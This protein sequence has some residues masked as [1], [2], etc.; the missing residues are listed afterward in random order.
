MDKDTRNAI[1]RAT[2]KIRRIL[3]EDFA[4]QLDGVFDVRSDGR[5][6]EE[7]GRH[8]SGRQLLLRD[9]I[10]AAVEHK[11]RAGMQPTD[12]VRDY[13]RDAA[14]TTLNRFA[15]LKM[16]EPRGLVQECISRGENSIGFTEFCGLA[17][18]LKTVD[19]AGYRL[20]IE[21]I[22]DELST[23]VKV[24]FDRRDPASALWPRKAAFDEILEI[25]NGSG[26]VGVWN[27]DETIGWIYQFFNSGEERRQ[28]REESQTPR[29]GR[30]LAIR[31]QFF[32]P[33]YVVRF[34]AENSLA[35]IW[36]EMRR[37]DTRI[38]LESEYLVCESFDL[39]Q[40]AGM[41][42][43]Q[44]RTKKDPRSLGAI[45]PACGSGHF[46]LYLF[47][48]F[49][50]IYEEAWHDLDAPTF[51][52]S[53]RTLREDFPELEEF[54]K[55]MPGLILRYNLFGIDIDF[56]CAQIA[57]LALWMRAQRAFKEMNVSRAARPRI[58]RANIVIAEPIPG[59]APLIENFASTL[60]PAALGTLFKGIVAELNHADEM[61]AL[62]PL[63]RTLASLIDEANKSIS[64]AR[65]KGKQATLPGFDEQRAESVRYVD[66]RGFS[67][68]QEAEA[69]L[70]ESLEEF[71][72]NAVNG[73]GVR[74][75]LFVDDAEQ[76]LALVD[77]MNRHYDVIV[78]NPPFGTPSDGARERIAAEYP[79]TKYDLGAAF[80][81]EW[82][83]RLTPRGRLGVIFNRTNWFL[84]RLQH[85]R[86]RLLERS[87]LAC[88]A[89][90]GLGVLDA[91]VETAMTVI[92]NG[93][94]EKRQSIWFRLTEGGDREG[95]L[96]RFVRDVN[97][98]S[99]TSNTFIHPQ[100][101][102]ENIAGKA[103]S[104]WLSP[105]LLH[106][107]E[108]TPLTASGIEAK[109]GLA[110]KDNFRFLRL[111]WE[112]K[113]NGERWKLYSKGGAY[114][115][116][117][118]LYHL[119]IDW[120]AAASAAYANRD[121]QFC[122]LLTGQ[123]HKYAFR[124]CITYSQRTSR[125]SARVFPAKG[126]FDTKGSAVFSP[127]VTTESDDAEQ[128]V[129]LCLLLNTSLGQFLF[130][131]SG[132][133]SDEGK[134]RDYSQ[135]MVG[136]LPGLAD[137]K[138]AMNPVL[139]EAKD[140][141]GELVRL[142]GS[143]PTSIYYT[144][145]PS[146]SWMNSSRPED[147]VEQATNLQKRLSGLLREAGT[148]YC[149]ALG[150]DAGS[151]A[152][153]DETVRGMHRE[154]VHEALAI[155]PADISS[156]IRQSILLSV[157]AP[158][159]VGGGIVQQ[160]KDNPLL[161]VAWSPHSLSES[162]VRVLVTDSGHELDLARRMSKFCQEHKLSDDCVRTWCGFDDFEEWTKLDAFAEHVSM[163][164]K[165]QRI[166]PVLWQIGTADGRY[167]IWLLS[168][169]V[170][171]NTLLDVENDLV[172]PKI[173]SVKRELEAFRVETGAAPT[174]DQRK[175][176]ES[177]ESFS[178]NLARFRDEIVKVALLFDPHEEDGATIC[179][180]PLYRLFPQNK[181]WQ[182]ELRKTWKD[183]CDGKLDWSNVAMR[184]WPERVIPK[185]AEDLSFAI[186]HDVVD[187]FWLKNSEGKWQ[188][189]KVPVQ[190]IE[191]LVDER[192]SLNVK[193][194][195]KNFIESSDAAGSVKRARK[196]K[197][198]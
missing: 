31:N 144:G 156:Q 193:T 25:L 110:T 53:G 56:R 182:A 46:L 67:S 10:V 29:D 63:D 139:Q 21:S 155:D 27:E 167:S 75:R 6:A 105:A 14:F 136:A 169:M 99:V 149:D 187:V 58:R 51:Q 57:Q 107:K 19:G 72:I 194:A 192:T 88:N 170:N 122:C 179:A 84:S 171:R 119:V 23:E 175:R 86:S 150:L 52:G 176:L 168:Y 138:R 24:L 125:F 94:Q 128:L 118:G 1:E 7:G 196:S 191:S 164:S 108:L 148:R 142:Q 181:P 129:A 177:L 97:S 133:A 4:E 141:I 28:M 43:D 33:N 126:L 178:E 174:A 153:V 45:D 154:A 120:G 160:V 87:W 116:L 82:R 66:L 38:L 186:A 123:A 157:F 117:V 143:D 17:P 61:G 2:Q 59:D 90:L 12:A 70:K 11:R 80:V 30:E 137:I 16:L 49:L 89:D 55:A 81:D 198:A 78:M 101:A 145:L 104:Y 114:A 166:A 159:K 112:L 40:A 77:L 60:K 26:L 8:L 41:S 185:C 151:Q 32:T 134:A 197:A 96:R 173:A 22:F 15:A 103:F 98:R 132:G 188:V 180:A 161:A 184:L 163:F 147:I 47:G 152:F 44:P 39:D 36:W 121:G 131:S 37:G 124:P 18:G 91:F 127:N 3:Q 146:A 130:D 195:L 158:R 48:L 71:L 165:S 100:S 74:R 115:P 68:F 109:Q 69:L 54:R 5:V 190:S 111:H 50:M 65:E 93:P 13:I 92:E 34:L 64:Q 189:R 85:F 42:A 102:F 106:I 183:L 62:L 140:V 83:N 162:P 73:I 79:Q 20:Y 9:R 35:R 76:G 135:G 95:N 172:V 113:Q